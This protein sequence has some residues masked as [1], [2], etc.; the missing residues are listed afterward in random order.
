MDYR[1]GKRS[2]MSIGRLQRP[3]DQL[4]SAGGTGIYQRPAPASLYN[5]RPGIDQPVQQMVCCYQHSSPLFAVDWSV[6]DK[7]ALGTYKEDSFNKLCI[8]EPTPDLVYW[9]NTQHANLLYP[10]SKLQWMPTS[11]TRLATCS[12]SL[13]VWSVDEELQERVNLSLSKYGND[14]GDAA[15]S[16]TLGQLPPVTSFDWNSVDTNIILSC[17]VDTT[18]TIWDLQA[19][20]Y[21]KTQLIAHD[22]DVY[23]AKFL[24][25]SNNLFASC[26]GDGSVRVFDLRCLAH[27]T[28]IYEPQRQT[29]SNS[30]SEIQISNS[31]QDG[32]E[33]RK[34][35]ESHVSGLENNALLRLEPSPFEA[36]LLATIRQDSNAVI[37]LDMR[38]PGSPILTL[39]G[40]VGAVNQIKW[41]PSKPHVLI[42]CGDDCQVLYWDLLELL[43]DNALTSGTPQQRW[44]SSGTVH[45]VDV[46][47]MSFTA[48]HEVNNL[49]WRPKGDWIGYVA[50]KRFRN[51]KT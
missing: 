43:S 28:I 30:P 49:T 9:K 3:L 16:H 7:V 26:G 48:Q 24:T 12:D 13:R 29:N 17:S 50:G 35:E 22:S 44:S 45:S 6:G 39:T 31:S 23:D 38:Y 14:A 25:Q 40:H 18:C 51:L 34:A 19:S 21:V 10:I 8:V 47:Q 15:D 5:S 11:T 1:T 37:I 46:P 32:Q 41:H 27:S 4:Q 2:S 42:S 20:N 36:N 33:Q